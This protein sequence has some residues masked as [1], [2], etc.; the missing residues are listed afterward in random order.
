MNEGKDG[1]KTRDFAVATNRRA[2]HDYFVEQTQRDWPQLPAGMTDA[3]RALASAAFSVDN[4]GDVPTPDDFYDRI[5]MHLPMMDMAKA[6]GAP[7][8]EIEEY[9]ARAAGDAAPGQPLVGRASSSENR[10]RS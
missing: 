2:L 1:D 7:R 8:T 10:S 3:E 4:Q 5:R 6:A 9:L